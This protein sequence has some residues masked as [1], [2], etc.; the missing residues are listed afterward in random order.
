[1]QN[2]LLD[3]EC[4]HWSEAVVLAGSLLVKNG[5]AREAY[6]DEM[7]Q[8]VEKNGEYMV[9]TKGVAMPHAG[10]SKVNKAGMSLVRLRRPIVF[11]NPFH[12]PVDLVFALC[13]PTKEGHLVALKQFS[14]LITDDDLL[15]ALRFAKKEK[16]IVE[17]LEA[18]D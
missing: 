6:I 10:L 5:F 2:I 16:E 9:V 7:L 18:L 8:N 17:I 4:D 1:L 11:G 14:V 13:T 15:Y 3:A 12:D